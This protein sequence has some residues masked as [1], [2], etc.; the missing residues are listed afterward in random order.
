MN[1]PER[2]TFTCAKEALG[3]AIAAS[4]A[5]TAVMRREAEDLQVKFSAA[6]EEYARAVPLFLPR[7][8]PYRTEAPYAPFSS[9][10]FWNNG[11]Y[12]A[13]SSLLA[14][15]GRMATYTGQEITWDMAWNSREDLTPPRYEWG[16]IPA[17]P[18]AVPGSTKFV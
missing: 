13:K 12:M 8:S 3:N 9:Q 10:L 11:E 14:I 16:E 1:P 6:Y 17:P 2:I 15:M 7:W 5:N 4:T 18:V